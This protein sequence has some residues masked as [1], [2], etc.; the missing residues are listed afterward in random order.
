MAA[1][2]APNTSETAAG[3]PTSWATAR[4]IPTSKFCTYCVAATR[5]VLSEFT[6]TTAIDRDKAGRRRKGIRMFF[7]PTGV[8]IRKSPHNGG[9]NKV[10]S[11]FE[12]SA[13][14]VLGDHY[15]HSAKSTYWKFAQLFRSLELEESKPSVLLRRM[16]KLARDGIGEDAQK[17]LWLERLPE[18]LTYQYC[19]PTHSLI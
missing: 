18:G 11:N 16:R 1:A 12:L 10:P 6:C 14:R 5:S 13:G 4:F 9:Q 2:D 19:P 8:A 15:V 7:Y 17:A 3:D